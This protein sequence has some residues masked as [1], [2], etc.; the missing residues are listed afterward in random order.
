MRHKL[1]ISVAI[2]ALLAL[3]FSG[4]SAEVIDRIVATVNGQIILQ[5]DWEDALRYEAFSNGRPLDLFSLLETEMLFI[6]VMRQ[7]RSTG[8]SSLDFRCSCYPRV[9]R[10]SDRHPFTALWA[11]AALEQRVGSP[12]R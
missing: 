5:S 3:A 11:V 7:R 8:R 12:L 10:T 6:R 4:A 1:L 9:V 2:L